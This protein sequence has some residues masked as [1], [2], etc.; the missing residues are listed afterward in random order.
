MQVCGS[1]SVV[2]H[3]ENGLL[4]VD[5][6]LRVLKKIAD[7]TREARLLDEKGRPRFNVTLYALRKDGT[8]GCASMH[9]GYEHIEQRGDGCRVVGN[10]FL[11]E[12]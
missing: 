7:C 11:F 9:E 3:M 10:A 12:K 6:C 2:Q 5:A 8:T 4:P 1:H